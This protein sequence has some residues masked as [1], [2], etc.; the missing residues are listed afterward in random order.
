M[1][2]KQTLEALWNGEIA[3]G[4]TNGV[5]DPQMEHLTVLM[6]RNREKLEK[7]LTQHQRELFERF[8]DCADEF[9]YLTAVQAFC[10]G[11]CLA[12]KLMTEAL[13]ST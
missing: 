2:V 10:D 6:D 7:L 13:T 12:S 9:Q 4:Q 11:F 5:Y 1:K 8:T 3:P